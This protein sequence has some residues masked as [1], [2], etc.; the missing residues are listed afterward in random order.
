MPEE[1]DLLSAIDPFIGRGLVTDVLYMVKSGKEATV[2]CCQAHPSTGVD[3]LAAKVY[4]PREERTFKNDALYLQGRRFGKARES[5][6]VQRKTRFGREV[7]FGTWVYRE[8]E[9]LN[10]LHRAGAAVPKPYSQAGGAILM[11][12]AGNE[13]GPAPMLYRLSLK[14][15]EAEIIYKLVLDNIALWL[16]HNIVHADLSAYNILYWQGQAR[17]I[18]FP[19]AVD[20]RFNASARMLLA[21]DIANVCAHFAHYGLQADPARITARL[22]GRYSV[23][24]ER[25]QGLAV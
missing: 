13:E 19:Q 9:V 11:E 10:L 22:W 21:R 25:V 5:R 1:S 12:Y 8:W 3:F 20:A 15:Q 23:G 6:A 14:P 24:G 18:D 17:I 4:R 7:Q 2:F 16:R